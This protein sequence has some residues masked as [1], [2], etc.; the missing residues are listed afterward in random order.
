M[1]ASVTNANV[2]V[3]ITDN[4]LLAFV[5][6]EPPSN[7]GSPPTYDSICAALAKAGVTQNINVKKIKELAEEPVYGRNIIIATGI[8]SVNGVDGTATL[9]F[10]TEKE[11]LRPKENSDGRVDYRDLGLVEN[12]KKGQIL[13]TIVLPTEGSEGISVKGE[14]LIQRRGKPATN[15][16]GP[17]TE[18]SQ[19]GTAILSKI[20]GFVELKNGRI[21]VSDTFTLSGDVDLTTG[22]IAVSGN[23]VIRGGIQPG[24]R[25][26]AT[27][28]LDVCGT[29]ESASIK[30]GGN[31]RLQS[32]ITGS[33]LTCDGDLK[34]RFIEGC[35]VFVKGDITA[36]YVLHS[37]IKC[38][39]NLKVLG[40]QAKII[41]G[42]CIVGQ[43]I[44]ACFIGSV[45]TVKTRLEIGTDPTIIERQ[46]SLL[47]QIPKLEKNIESLRPLLALLRQLEANNRLTPEKKDALEDASYSYETYTKLLEDARRELQE[48]AEALYA[49]GYGRV[50]CSGIIYPGTNIII[51]SAKLTVNETLKN[52]TVSNYKGLISQTPTR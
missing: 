21:N 6:I 49:R 12:V 20:D 50:V 47:A 9:Q 32:G 33:S 16:L 34:S 18:L 38:G 42:N 23:L 44:E 8:A 5:L 17:N 31:V 22:N 30:A 26:E 3:S 43:N 40:S 35:N 45:A 52:T 41:G 39:K 14:R 27:G 10:D 24:F 28:Y 15:Y 48:I 11:N 25:V 2:Q 46:Q 13:C 1:D 51:G 29:A 19:D 4:G 7:G 37:D 36:E